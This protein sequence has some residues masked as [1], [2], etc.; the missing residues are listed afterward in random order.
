MDKYK[1]T[2]YKIDINNKSIN[3]P[4]MIHVLT[5]N[6]TQVYKHTVHNNNL[7]NSVNYYFFH[8]FTTFTII[9]T[10]LNIYN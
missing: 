3:Y 7:I 5:L 1:K 9:T 6:N 4:K 2:V 10:N 8:I